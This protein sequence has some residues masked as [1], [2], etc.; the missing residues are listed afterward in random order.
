MKLIKT[1]GTVMTNAVNYFIKLKCEE[2]THQKPVQVK[3]FSNEW[4][5]KSKL[6]NQTCGEKYV[7]FSILVLIIIFNL[8]FCNLTQSL[9]CIFF[10]H[11]NFQFWKTKFFKLKL[12]NEQCLDT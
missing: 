10:Y 2:K 3:T 12:K 8:E 6:D 1:L 9:Y 5:G 7:F 11:S 4:K